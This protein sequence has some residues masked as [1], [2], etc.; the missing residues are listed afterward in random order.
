MGSWL[1]NLFQPSPGYCPA[2]PV[3]LPQD[4]TDILPPVPPSPDPEP[5][6]PSKAD[7]IAKAAVI[8]AAIA[9]KI[10][11]EDECKTRENCMAVKMGTGG[12]PPRMPYAN[13]RT[14]R[15]G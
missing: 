4:I 6:P 3:Q 1:E 12:I 13:T 5:E 9:Q 10:K 15:V 11:E 2:P 14:S 7:L 8:A